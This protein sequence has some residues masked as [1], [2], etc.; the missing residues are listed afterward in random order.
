MLNFVEMNISTTDTIKIRRI[1]AQL[2]KEHDR[3]RAKFKFLQFQGFIG[4][5][6]LI[7]SVFGI[8]VSS[9]L[10]FVGV[11][12]T[13]VLVLIIAF[14][15]SILHELEHDL[16]HGLY[17][18]KV[19]FI[20]NIM[21][22]TVWFFRPLTLNP[23]IRK[24]WHYNHHQ[25]SGQPID[26]E[27]RGVTN[28]ERWGFMRLLITADLVLGFVFRVRRLKREIKQEK[29]NGNFSDK[30]S[31]MLK[32]TVLFG[33]LPFG[34]PLH[35]LFYC[36]IV[37]KSLLY[38]NLVSTNYWTNEFM[39]IANVIIYIFVLPNLLR[40]FCLHFITSNMHY[41]GDIEE[42]N[43]LQQT[44]V[45]NS[46]WTWPFQLFCFNFGSTHSI[47][48]FVVNEPFYL[49]QMSVKKAHEV[50]KQEGI[51]FNDTMSFKNANRYGKR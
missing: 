42:G 43:I 8:L 2:Q 21:L 5:G 7:I 39:E 20:H 49:R 12:S 19:K 29:I 34:I 6:L 50:F 4:L 48:H 32:N 40:Q 26:I 10:W 22:F 9:Y 28:G 15:N 3:L 41:Y 31:K 25:H 51:R 35:I 38:F 37:L 16:I 11:M 33:L 45:L 36:W 23:W 1:T 47:H 46:W 44:Q 17:F 27:E 18:K 14:W 13:I 30:D 24:Y